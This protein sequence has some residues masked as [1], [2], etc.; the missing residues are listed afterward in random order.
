MNCE[1]QVENPEEN[2][3]NGIR[4]ASLVDNVEIFSQNLQEAQNVKTP[5]FVAK[6]KVLSINISP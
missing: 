6:V 5:V 4:R 3:R 1:F 2:W